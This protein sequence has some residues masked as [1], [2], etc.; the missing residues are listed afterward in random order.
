MPLLRPPVC[1]RLHDELRGQVRADAGRDP[2]PTAVIDSQ[3]VRGAGTVPRVGRGL[4]TRLGQ[5][6]Q[7]AQ[8]YRC[9]GPDHHHRGHRRQRQVRG[10]AR[11]LIW[12]LH[13]VGAVRAGGGYA[14]KLGTSAQSGLTSS[15]RL[16]K[17]EQSAHEVE[18]LDKADL[19]AA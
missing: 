8:R 11:P 6:P 19:G 1:R 7:A 15:H 13:R 18:L 10:T 12:N 3:S 4:G 5:R 2:E 14:G 17:P 16:T 9:P